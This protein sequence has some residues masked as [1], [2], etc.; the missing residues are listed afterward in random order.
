M[1]TPLRN[2]SFEETLGGLNLLSLEKLPLPGKLI[3]CFKIVKG[4]INADAS[5][6]FQLIIHH[7]L[8]VTV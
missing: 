1:V 2:K 8:V 4:F 5:K 7:E 6:L 3:E